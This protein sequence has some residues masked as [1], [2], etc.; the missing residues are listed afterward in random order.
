MKQKELRKKLFVKSGGFAVILFLILLSLSQAGARNGRPR[1]RIYPKQDQIHSLRIEYL[2]QQ[3]FPS[4]QQ[5]IGS[6][7]GIA[8]VRDGRQGRRYIG[9][10]SYGGV[11]NYFKCEPFP[12]EVAIRD[13]L[14]AALSRSGI[15]TVLISNWDR[16]KES[17]KDAEADAIL[18]VLIDRFWVEG[19]TAPAPK[20]ETTLYLSF[21]LGVKKEG[22]VFTK[23]VYFGTNETVTRFTPERMERAVQQA[24]ASVFESFFSDPY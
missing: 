14:S 16:K 1:Q 19:R 17:L 2:P 22:V 15:R 21:R 4:L 3:V 10:Y 6:T 5:K 24:V 7:I 11:S 12:L 13:T 8:P 23:R 18:S 9:H 20:L